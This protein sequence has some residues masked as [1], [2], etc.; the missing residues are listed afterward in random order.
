[1]TFIVAYEKQ[2]KLGSRN[3]EAQLKT[4]SATS[5]IFFFF[6]QIT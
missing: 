2:L 3:E 4:F 6:F 1:M 5:Q